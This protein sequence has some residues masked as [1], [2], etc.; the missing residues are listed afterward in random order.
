MNAE[1][2]PLVLDSNEMIFCIILYNL[3]F[4]RKPVLSHRSVDFVC[5]NFSFKDI[6][7]FPFSEVIPG[8]HLNI[9]LKP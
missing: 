3:Y 2:K 7:N 6:K 8:K 1:T 9:I 5:V 4:S